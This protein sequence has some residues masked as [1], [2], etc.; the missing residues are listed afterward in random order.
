MP[1]PANLLSG[2]N[3]GCPSTCTPEDER[4]LFAEEHTFHIGA[5]DVLEIG[6]KLCRNK[7]SRSQHA[8]SGNAYYF[9]L[10]NLNNRVKCLLLTAG[11]NKP[12]PFSRTFTSKQISAP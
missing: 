4:G 3:L 2:P 7:S 12:P 11:P 1:A 8:L 10:T 6:S 9:P 5:M